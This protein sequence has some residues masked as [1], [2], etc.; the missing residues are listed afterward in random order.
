[1]SHEHVVVREWSRWMK[2]RWTWSL[3]VNVNTCVISKVSSR[4]RSINTCEWIL[5]LSRFA[6]FAAFVLRLLAIDR[7][8]SSSPITEPYE[9][10]LYLRLSINV[11]GG[12]F[13]F[14]SC[15][16]GSGRDG[17]LPCLAR[18]RNTS[19]S[20]AHCNI[21]QRWISTTMGLLYDDCMFLSSPFYCCSSFDDI[22]RWRSLGVFVV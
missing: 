13:G 14:S 16:G 7:S 12:I 6:L 2:I 21:S 15:A 10:Q 19:P 18:L 4:V 20:Q 9:S 22:R 17:R 11:E 5:S 8:L 3:S 1:M